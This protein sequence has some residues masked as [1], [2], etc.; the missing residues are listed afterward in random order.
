M[1]NITL[2]R[3]SNVQA[4]GKR[5][6]KGAS[7]QARRNIFKLSGEGLCRAWAYSVPPDL[8][9]VA[10]SVKITWGQISTALSPYVP[11]GLAW[12]GIVEDAIK[13]SVATT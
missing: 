12:T 3:A 9:R 7:L 2:R 5:P 6:S 10:E 8:K 1:K 4:K 11:L 13:A